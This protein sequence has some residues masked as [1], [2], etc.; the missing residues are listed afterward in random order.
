MLA[1][2]TSCFSK[3]LES[4]SPEN[5]EEAL[6]EVSITI[7]GSI[8][9][10]LIAPVSKWEVKVTLFA[11]HPEK[12]PGP[13]GMSALSYQKFWDIVNDD[14]TCMVNQFLFE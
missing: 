5:I 14:L 1:V 10:D 3:I 4:S 11:M 6:Y 2:A 8:N 7:T 13:D 9:D 12:A